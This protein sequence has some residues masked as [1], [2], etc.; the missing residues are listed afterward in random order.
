MDRLKSRY[1][2][3]AFKMGRGIPAGIHA[4]AVVDRGPIGFS[5][6]NIVELRLTGAGGVYAAQAA[7]GV[8]DSFDQ[9]TP[10]SVYIKGTTN[11]DGLRRVYNLRSG[12]YLQVFASYVAET[13]SGAYGR[14]GYEAEVASEFGGFSVHFASAYTASSDLVVTIHSADGSAF[15]NEVFSRDML[16]EQDINHM[17]SPPRHLAPGDRI[18]LTFLPNMVCGIMLY[19]RKLL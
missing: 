1:I 19:V 4:V 9:N 6:E 15:D 3:Y 11:Y 17:F 5:E 12:R 7:A 16:G 14:C 13:P 8:I 10:T 18:D 2:G